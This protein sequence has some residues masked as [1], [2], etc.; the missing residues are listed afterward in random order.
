M[1]NVH[2]FKLHRS[3]WLL[4]GLIFGISGCISGQETVTDASAN[5][6]FISTSTKV[7][8]TQTNVAT[9]SL[10]P[11]PLLITAVPPTRI[12]D[13]PTSNE[14]Y[15]EKTELFDRDFT[16][17][18]PGSPTSTPT[19]TPAPTLSPEQEGGLLSSLMSDNGGCELP[20]WWGVAPS[21]T[22][23][24][25]ARDLFASQG[26]DDWV[27]SNDETYALMGL[28]YPKS[29]TNN[30]FRDMIVHFGIENNLIQYISVEGSYRRELNSLLVR[31][32]QSY[33]ATEILRRYGIPNYIEFVEVENSPYFRLKLSYESLGIEISYILPFESLDNGRS[34]I[35]FNLQNVDF[36]GLSL[37]SP[38]NAQD[39]PVG[40]IPNR[41][42]S[43]TSWEITTGLNKE[44]FRQLLE[45]HK[46]QPCIV[47]D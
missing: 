20:C 7:I 12:L 18:T 44:D 1:S 37:Y 3:T 10:T 36:I 43:Y 38:E 21:Q 29:G 9:P 28:G 15:E 8:V 31:D 5:T 32:W 35:C 17:N 14:V 2:F 40:I 24:Q 26:I 41:L 11:G 33:S 39:V 27:V 19:V 34:E 13:T 30:S 22:S 6:T 4:L 42:D 23:P 46:N 16:A 25:E 45:N 47:V